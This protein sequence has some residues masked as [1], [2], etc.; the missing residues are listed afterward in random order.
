MIVST[1]FETFSL[2]RPPGTND[3]RQHARDV[4][5]AHRCSD[6]R[7]GRTMVN[8]ARLVNSN[9]LSIA[10]IALAR[11]AN[12]NF[13]ANVSAQRAESVDEMSYPIANL[14]KDGSMTETF[15]VVYVT[16]CYVWSASC[17]RNCTATTISRCTHC[18]ESEDALRRSHRRFDVHALDLLPVLWKQTNQE[19]D[20]HRHVRCNL[21]L[22]H[23]NVGNGDTHAH[24]LLA[25]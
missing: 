11:A 12:Q 9:A 15:V 2:P 3:G 5:A 13:A 24:R 20:G 23:F 22:R 16:I 21:L 25:L 19:V 1:I 8:G 10:R 17:P 4:Y 6:E 7:Q 18:L 14:E